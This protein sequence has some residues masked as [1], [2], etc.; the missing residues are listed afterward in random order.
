MQKSWT[1]DIGMLAGSR[2]DNGS[3]LPKENPMI[4]LEIDTSVIDHRLEVRSE[5]LPANISH[6]KVIVLYEEANVRSA[7]TSKTGGL[8]DFLA[9][10]F[11][12]K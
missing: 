10:P 2:N 4:A 11:H 7:T 1:A 3:H 12:V 5:R 6:A 8:A 9:H